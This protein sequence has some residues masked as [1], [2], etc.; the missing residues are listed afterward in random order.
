MDRI[1]AKLQGYSEVAGKLLA[2]LAALTLFVPPFA[3]QCATGEVI[4]FCIPGYCGRMCGD[5]RET[6]ACCAKSCCQAG[7][8]GNQE[9][10]LATRSSSSCCHLIVQSQPPAT[11]IVTQNIDS[12]V[13]IHPAFLV[14]GFSLDDFNDGSRP[15]QIDTSPPPIDRVI[16]QLRLTI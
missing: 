13:A 8:Q 7:R 2:I 6:S 16:V 10:E 5:Q 4:P 1:K 11:K 14:Q 12:G 9:I 15:I 3:C